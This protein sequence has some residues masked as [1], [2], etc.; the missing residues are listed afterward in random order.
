M[1]ICS[2]LF[3][4]LW[5]DGRSL[6]EIIS[7]VGSI[8]SLFGLIIAI[9]QIQSVKD[10]TV[11]TQRA[12]ADTKAQLIQNISISDLAQAIK[13]IEH[14]QEYLGNSKLELAYVRLQDLRVLLIQFVASHSIEEEEREEYK[15]LLKDI[16]IHSVNLYDA[17]Y[18]E[19]VIR[20]SGI[21]KTLQNAAE[22]LIAAENQLR[23]GVPK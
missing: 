4:K 2:G 9:L 11:A 20:V 18:K 3:L 14:I 8:A 23:L 17:V 13:L 5:R 10:I 7:A 22:I 19:K 12:V 15:S 16:G 6:L 1:V 21:N